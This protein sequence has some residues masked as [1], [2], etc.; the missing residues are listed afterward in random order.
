VLWQ[1]VPTVTVWLNRPDVE[2]RGNPG[3]DATTTLKSSSGTIKSVHHATFDASGRDSGSFTRGGLPVRTRAGDTVST[4]GVGSDAHWKV[5]AINVSATVPGSVVTGH[6]QPGKG[7][8][9][10]IFE[11]QYNFFYWNVGFANSSGNYSHNF[12]GD[13]VLASGDKIQVWCKLAT[14]D[15]VTKLSTIS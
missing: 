13:Q 6:C 8:E 12:S 7:V 14:G 1:D 9:L 3:G 5:P 15:V 10:D 4:P 11:A 2:A